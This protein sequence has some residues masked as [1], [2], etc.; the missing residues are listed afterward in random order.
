MGMKEFDGS[1][2][3][4]A[5]TQLIQDGIGTKLLWRKK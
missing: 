5:V 2:M 1:S 3:K 4:K